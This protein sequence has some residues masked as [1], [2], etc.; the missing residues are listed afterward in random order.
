MLVC[1]MYH[2]LPINLTRKYETSDDLREMLV[3]PYTEAVI[4][5]TIILP[6]TRKM[7]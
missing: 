7:I 3:E 2:N 4:Y 1:L 6:E 5:Y